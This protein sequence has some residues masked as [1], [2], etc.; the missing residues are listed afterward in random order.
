LLRLVQ[1]IKSSG[2][3]PMKKERFE[4][5]VQSLG[6]VRD[7]VAT[8]RFA[9]RMSEVEVAADAIRAVRERL[10]V[11]RSRQRWCRRAARRPP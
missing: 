5:L 9:G 8:G 10:G 6:E 3:E 2:E 11:T 7:H 1:D 4:R